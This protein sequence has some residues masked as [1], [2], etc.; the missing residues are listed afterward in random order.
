M[1]AM[2]GIPM[3]ASTMRENQATARMLPAIQSKV[4]Q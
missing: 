1:S 3:A 2:W 4:R